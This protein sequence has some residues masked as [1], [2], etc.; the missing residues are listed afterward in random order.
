MKCVLL[1]K[2][3]F[4]FD[5]FMIWII[6]YFFV[7]FMLVYLSCGVYVNFCV[8]SFIFRF[9]VQSFVCMIFVMIFL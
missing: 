6:V 9:E 7:C 8:E 4:N 2:K 5:G 3:C 1:L